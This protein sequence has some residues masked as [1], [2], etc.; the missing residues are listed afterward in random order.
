MELDDHSE[1]S[2]TVEM[3]DAQPAPAEAPDTS[4]SCSSRRDPVR[5]RLSRRRRSPPYPSAKRL[6][7]MKVV[8]EKTA[9][10]AAEARDL[11]DLSLRAAESAGHEHAAGRARLAEQHAEQVELDRQRAA[12][13][14]AKMAEQQ[15][16]Y[17]R[18][19]ARIAEQARLEAE[20]LR[21]RAEEREKQRRVDA[22]QR[23]LDEAAARK[24]G[25]EAAYAEE[26]ARVLRRAAVRAGK[27]PEQ[28]PGHV[29][30]N[31]ALAG[32]EPD[33]AAASA[34]Q[35]ASSSSFVPL[36]AAPVP[37]IVAAGFS[38]GSSSVA[39]IF[40]AHSTPVDGISSSA[41]SPSPAVPRAKRPAGSRPP[42]KR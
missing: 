33:T 15:M 37:D 29:G 4:K 6:A 10:R 20:H 25:K 30:P 8:A 18:L 1:E 32:S 2:A 9:R 14:Q 34:T 22:L 39:P 5:L 41:G 27:Q 13:K 21:A 42:R 11:A 24:A 40:G 35:P 38:V 7:K 26:E 23:V 12:A 19:Q 36:L 17:E 31:L 28:Q 16:E 3:H